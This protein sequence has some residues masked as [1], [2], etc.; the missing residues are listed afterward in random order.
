MK[1][2]DAA[3][4]ILSPEDSQEQLNH[5]TSAFEPAGCLKCIFWIITTTAVAV[6]LF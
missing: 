6:L 2:R 1:I 4:Y 5:L 3:R